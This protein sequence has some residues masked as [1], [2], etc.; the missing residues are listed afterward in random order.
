V[1][2]I[3]V[4]VGV[5]VIGWVFI[6]DNGAGKLNDLSGIGWWAIKSLIVFVFLAVVGLVFNQLLKNRK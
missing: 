4:V 5:I 3:L 6:Q 2:I 1:N